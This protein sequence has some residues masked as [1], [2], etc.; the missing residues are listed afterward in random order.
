MEGKSMRIQSKMIVSQFT[1]W[2]IMLF[3][4]AYPSSG[5]AEEQT[6]VWK[7]LG[8]ADHFAIL[9]HA[10]APG[11]GDPPGLNLDDCRTQRN[12][13]NEGRRQAELIGQRFRAQG[14]TTAGVYSSQ[15]CRCLE[16]AELLNL[17]K[18]EELPVLNSFFADFDREEAQTRQLKQWLD[19]Q[20]LSELVVLVSHQV[21]ITALTGIY[22]RSGELV[23]VER[24]EDRGLVVKGTVQTD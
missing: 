16:T 12:L 2:I 7:D 19:K 15:W 13:S 23:V 22:P 4:T 21:N 14:Y 8:S 24:T 3:F 17:G 9:R 6:A 10:I 1:I 5:Y 11:M 18:V 20:D